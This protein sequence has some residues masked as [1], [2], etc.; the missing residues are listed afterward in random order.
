MR[1]SPASLWRDRDGA[2]AAEFAMILPL[3]LLFLFGIIDAGRLMW[4]WN[5]AEQATQAGARYAVATNMLPSGL[6]TY[7]FAV[8]GGLPQGTA[9]P[10][11]AF[12]GV[13]CTSGG[14]TCST[15]TTCPP[16]GA[17]NGT[18]F[19]LIVQRMQIFLPEI[20]A[21]NVRVDYVNSGLGFAGDPNA[22]DVAPNV[23]VSLTGL[24]FAPITTLMFG[25]SVPMPDFHSSL[26]LEDGSG[27]R[28]N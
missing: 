25:A 1:T 20:Q 16:L 23:T 19:D 22:P 26:T 2:S 27:R 11:S 18:D 15:G 5:R 6:A 12:G 10:T 9:I 3:L 17:F 7:D 21:A 24:D 14:C 13:T 4:T 8:D 28:S